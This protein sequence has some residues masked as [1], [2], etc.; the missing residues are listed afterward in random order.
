M[1][2]AKN[3]MDQEEPIRGEV[4]IVDDTLANLHLLNEMLRENGY[5]VRGALDGDIALNAIRAAPPDLVLLDINMPGKNGY[6]VC[7]EL[8]AD[9]GTRRIPVVFLSAQSEPIDKITAFEVGGADYVSKPFQIEEVLVRIDHQLKLRRLERELTEARIAAEAASQAKSAFLANMSHEIRTPMNA[10]LGYAQI[11]SDETGLSDLQRTAVDT[12]ETSGNHLLALIND[13]LD[14]SKIE[15]G[16]EELQQEDFSL[17]DF[18]REVEVL[19]EIRCQQKGLSW[20]LEVEVEERRVHGDA[21]KMRQVLINLLGNAVKFTQIGEVGLGL[22]RE[23]DG[24]YCFEVRDSGPGIPVE[25]QQEV[26]KPFQQEASGI[27][28][29]GTGLGL[30]IAQRH[31]ELM[32]GNIDLV[33]AEGEGARFS[34]I[35]PLAAAAGPPA[36]PSGSDEVWAGPCRLGVG[37]TVRALVVDDVETSRD[38][39]ARMLSA[40][41][42]SVIVAD[43]GASALAMSEAPPDIA[44][45]DIRMPGMDGME[46]LHA[47]HERHGHKGFIAV[48]VSASALEHQRREYLDAGF[49]WFMEK[50][51]LRQHIC[52]CLA[53]LL[54]VCFEA[55]TETDVASEPPATRAGKGLSLPSSQLADLRTAAWGNNIT[56]LHDALDVLEENS[57][58]AL[59][60][61]LRRFCDNYDFEGLRAALREIDEC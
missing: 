45:I 53:N 10:I 52:R 46:L 1:D 23:E 37:Y 47:L 18:V 9:D 40:F 15:A 36:A 32:G 21:K 8:K 44:F 31:A 16:R 14:L 2:S 29:G 51:V 25:R 17:G 27:Q 35:V 34:F 61:R 39:L 56:G 58:S 5:K 24:R 41:G 50:P 19:F 60:G 33:S 55:L 48:A 20:R 13:I 59:A 22:Y 3:D 42:V 11:M 26:F 38:I 28:H 49:A 6:E 4:L 12:I 7:R 54:G 30:A 57:D 43:C